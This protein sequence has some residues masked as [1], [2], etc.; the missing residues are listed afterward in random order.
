MGLTPD[1]ILNH[2][3]T[4]KGSRAY[5]ASEVDAFLDQIN[6]DYEA[7]IADRD[8]L[9]HENAQLHV[10]VDEL[11]AKREQVNQSIFVAQEAADR[12][13]QDADAE[14]KK[15]LMHAQESATKIISDARTK[16]AAEATYLA[17]E[18]AALVAEQNLLR[19]EVESFKDSFLKLLAQQRTLLENGDLAEAVH[20]LPMGEATAHRIGQVAV[21]STSVDDVVEEEVIA[22]AVVAE[23][24]QGPVVVFPEAET[25]NHN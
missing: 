17:E 4:K 1:E 24:E 3:F 9:V 5:V 14:V 21:E 6:S 13:K 18:N 11:E 22:E 12:L 25:P 8:R 2:E 19:A 15:Q 10:R 20:R 23:S 16:A 7:L